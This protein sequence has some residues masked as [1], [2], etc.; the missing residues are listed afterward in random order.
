TYGLTPA[1]VAIP[2]AIMAL[3]NILGTVLGG[4]AADRLP[5]RSRTF[6]L[7]MV[8]SGGAA[9]L[10]FGWTPGL[11]GTTALGFAYATFGAMSRPSLMA[12]LANVPEEVRGTV[13]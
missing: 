6:A 5:D 8:A 9:M 3:G 1:G 11:T 12:A 13:L 4:Q 2:L 10:L 7:A